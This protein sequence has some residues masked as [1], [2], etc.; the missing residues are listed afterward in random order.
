MRELLAITPP[1][2]REELERYRKADPESEDWTLHG[3]REIS[4]ARS[5]IPK[6]TE[7]PDLPS[8]LK[9]KLKNNT[10]LA[11][12]HV[13]ALRRHGRSKAR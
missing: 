1:D 7:V 10:S 9:N 6:L 13:V 11:L 2:E 5:V 8:D 4:L 12:F 3:P